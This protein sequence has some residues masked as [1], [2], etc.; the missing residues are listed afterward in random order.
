MW[1]SAV[2]PHPFRENE[3]IQTYWKEKCANRREAGGGR[4]LPSSRRRHVDFL[5]RG[6]CSSQANTMTSL[7]LSLRVWITNPTAWAWTG[8]RRRVTLAF[9][10][11]RREAIS[12]FPLCGS[13]AAPSTTAASRQQNSD[14]PTSQP[15]AWVPVATR[16][17]CGY[18]FCR[19]SLRGLLLAAT[20]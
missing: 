4:R 15:A 19:L 8:T 3:P 12:A 20:C 7:P 11:L 17:R 13:R 14:D 10:T 1:V 6:C 16:F 18:F 5:C 2:L 9:T